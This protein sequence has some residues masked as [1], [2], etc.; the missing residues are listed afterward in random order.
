MFGL[1]KKPTTDPAMDAQSK[2][3]ELNL[4]LARVS[5]ENSRLRKQVRDFEELENAAI[6][7]IDFDAVKVFSIERMKDPQKGYYTNI[8]YLLPTETVTG[9]TIAN[10]DEVKE[11]VLFCSIYQHNE[12]VNKFRGWLESK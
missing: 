7:E 4:E 1:F 11:W 3:N 12:L 10:T 8:G 2:I 5:N 6:F 9:G